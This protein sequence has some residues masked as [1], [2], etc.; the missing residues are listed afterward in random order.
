MLD[1][2]WHHL[3]TGL[4]RDSA[5]NVIDQPDDFSKNYFSYSFKTIT[6]HII[7]RILLLNYVY[8]IK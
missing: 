4:I 1:F 5:K 8:L 2:G 6:F 3:E 7:I